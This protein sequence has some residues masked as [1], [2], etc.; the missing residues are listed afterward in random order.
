MKNPALAKVYVS[1]KD[2]AEAREILGE[3]A[4]DM[5]E[6]ELREQVASMKY[7]GEAWLDE[8]EKK[9]FNGKTLQEKL[10]DL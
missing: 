9:I 5:T 2:L 4:K 1:E 3:Q 8:F 10:A 7:L 6:E